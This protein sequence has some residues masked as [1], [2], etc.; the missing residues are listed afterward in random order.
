VFR[1]QNALAEEIAAVLTSLAATTTPAGAPS[2]GAAAAVSG[3][4]TFYKEVSVVADK[5]TNSLIITA[6]PQ[7]Y[8][9]LSR[10]IE[11]LDI[12]RPQVLVETLIA[13]VSADFARELG[14]QWFAANPRG[15]D[16]GFV[17]VNQDTRETGSLGQSVASALLGTSDAVSVPGGLSVG[18]ANIDADFLR[19]FI[20]INASEGNTDFNVLSAPH[21]LTLDNEK[22]VINISDNVPFI[23][24]RIS[25]AETAV[26][27]S[28]TFEYR[29]VGI[30]LEI[31]P[32][33]SPERMVRLEIV[34]KVNEVSEV[35]ITGASAQLS[36]KK[37]EAETTLMVKDRHTLVL[38]GLMKDTDTVTISKVPFLGDIPV[39]GWAFKSKTN[40]RR[41][42]NLLIFITPS[43]V[44]TVAE[45]SE[46]TQEKRDDAGEQLRDRLERSSTMK[47]RGLIEGETKLIDVPLS[48]AG[49]K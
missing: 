12:M 2:G 43:I 36:E 49:P 45:A 41:K 37:R 32:H 39:L 4:R 6:T 42:T 31:T 18:Y 16:H 47:R 29:D 14:I 3:V 19:A 8:S 44:T 27:S 28:E 26:S 34:Q 46:L 9:V 33:I 17:G 24:G 38:G 13:E 20:E 23:T 11:Q 22:A 5:T 25:E 21:V 30:I 7:D 1:L 15:E 40:T 35:K 10:V 48:E